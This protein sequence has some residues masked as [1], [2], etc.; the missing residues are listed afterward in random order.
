MNKS[1]VK[2]IKP[3]NN[4]WQIDL[5]E[6]WQYR[7]LFYIFVWRDLKVRY[8]QTFLG[9]GWVV[10]QPLVT[11]TIFTIFFGN[12]AKIPS[13]QLPYPLFVLC[14]LVYWSFFSSALTHSSS[15]LIENENVIKKVF[16]PKIILPLSSIITCLVDFSI[17]L[18]ILL[19]SSILIF[20][21]IPSVSLFPITVLGALITSI[22]SCGLGMFL[23]ALNVKF[24]DVRYILPFFIQILIFLTPVIYPTSI[25]R[26]SN[27]LILAIN[28]LTWVIE[29]TRSAISGSFTL[30]VPHFAISLISSLLIFIGGLFYF[31]F[32]EKFFAD[33]I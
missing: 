15:S 2:I 31:R 4:W 32:T 16:F 9:I 8:K 10:F 25:A 19:L 27:Q 7:D 18:V 23:S 20:K 6:L 12:L 17:N 29:S 24:R 22:A 26:P 5:D 13:G 1:F 14:G 30:N 21:H 3:L 28:P 11:A 33:I